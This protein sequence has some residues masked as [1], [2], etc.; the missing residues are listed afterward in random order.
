M[1]IIADENKLKEDALSHTILNT[2]G[3]LLQDDK[4]N[5]YYLYPIYRGDL[6]EDLVQAQILIT[7]PDY[8]VIYFYC[9]KDPSNMTMDEMEYLENL[10]SNIYK[11]FIA[12]SELRQNKRKLKFDVTGIVVSLTTE[13]KDDIHFVALADIVSFVQEQK[14]GEPLSADE[15]NIL[16]SC[17]DNTTKMTIKK[18]RDFMHAPDQKVT[19]GDILN[20]IQ[21]AEACFDSIQRKIALSC[22][23]S[24]QRIRGLAG[25]GKTILLTMKAAQ[26]HLSNPNADI[27]YTY[28]TKDLYEQIRTLIERFYREASDNHEPNWSKIHIL[29]AWGG[30]EL[31]GVYSEVCSSLKIQPLT[32]Q[33]ARARSLSNPFDYICGELLKH[34]LQPTYDLTLIDEGQDFHCEFYRLCYRLTKNRRI[35]W[36]YD[37]FQNIF[38]VKIQDEKDTFGKKPDGT[39]N[40]DFSLM[41]N[42]HQDEVLKF[43]YRT[44]RRV[45][46]AAFALGLGVYNQ[47]VLQRLPSN[48]LWES[49]GF[50]VEQGNCNDGDKMVISRPVESTPSILNEKYKLGSVS[51]KQGFN[52]VQEECEF[53]AENINKDI[54]DENLRA[55]D[56]CVICLDTRSIGSY[57]SYL[58]MMLQ[59]KSINTFNM[60]NASNNNRS[61]TRANCVTLA[62]L[63]KAKGNEKGMVYIMGVDSVFSNSDNVIVRNRLFTA[64]TRAKGWV[65]MTGVGQEP[66]SKCIRE[67]EEYKK[68]DM[69]LVFIQPSIDQTKSIMDSSRRE[70]GDLNDLINKIKNMQRKG[71]KVEDII[72]KMNL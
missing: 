23:D 71:Y 55:D 34:D 14:L 58:S 1:N 65:I 31:D 30:G 49:L 11:R 42:P 52:N 37:D 33:Q 50:E 67:I 13:D 36:A 7:S 59:T 27:L 15:Y 72:N 38:D 45:L 63:N 44:P 32:Y 35:V 2:I 4:S 18:L 3:E 66:V 47:K 24:P 60:L 5:A 9:P 40:V 53:V 70:E 8:G 61:F 39:Y 46:S 68:N 17:I 25:S 57:Y 43:C 48:N 22:I 51:C 56:I 54:N 62:T 21:N 20:M 41:E 10:D 69:K 29:H 64:M 26:Y 28:Y 16:V 12:R 6:P 19:K